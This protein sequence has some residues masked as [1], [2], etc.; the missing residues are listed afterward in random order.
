MPAYG[1]SVI[2][3]TSINRMEISFKTILQYQAPWIGT[4]RKLHGIQQS[5]ANRSRRIGTPVAHRSYAQPRMGY[6]LA[7]AGYL[8]GTSFCRKAHQGAA[9]TRRPGYKNFNLGDALS[10]YPRI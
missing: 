6:P 7:M 4:M 5:V 3:V 2:L 9:R 1:K 8:F 10:I